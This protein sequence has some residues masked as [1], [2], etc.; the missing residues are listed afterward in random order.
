MDKVPKIENSTS[1]LNEK[2]LIKINRTKRKVDV[3]ISFNCTIKSLQKLFGKKSSPETPQNT[4]VQLFFA[5]CYS[6]KDRAEK[7]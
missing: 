7:N 5:G 1:I 2:S 3:A 6:T 4:T